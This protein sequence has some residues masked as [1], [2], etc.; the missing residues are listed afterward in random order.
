[1]PSIP[2][3]PRSGCAWSWRPTSR[4]RLSHSGKDRS[5]PPF[6]DSL[7]VSARGV[8]GKDILSSIRYGANWAQMTARRGDGIGQGAGDE[9]VQA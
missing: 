7:S 9:V 3:P 1:M 6:A 8:P 4:Y 2:I 5:D